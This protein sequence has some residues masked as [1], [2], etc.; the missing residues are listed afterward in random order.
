MSSINLLLE[1][2][3]QVRNELQGYDTRTTQWSECWLR[4][5]N[6]ESLLLKELIKEHTRKAA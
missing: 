6:L 3:K 4:L 2:T 5:C 1:A